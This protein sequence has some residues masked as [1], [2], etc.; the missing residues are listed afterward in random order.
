MEGT[1]PIT[2][3]AIKAAAQRFW[4]QISA[5]QGQE[6]PRFSTGWL[7]G[8]KRRHNIKQYKQHG[9]AGDVDLKVAAI[10]MV[11]I[12]AITD[13]YSLHDIFNMDE[14]G[15][16]WKTALDKTLAHQQLPG[17]KKVKAR[18]TAALCYNASGL[19][20]LPVWLIGTARQSRAF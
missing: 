2:G 20:Q 19:E 4:L 5:Y 17:N 6:I 14:T 18:I 16:Y 12:K 15:L 1:V 13:K 3:D 11:S 9:E 10:A 8:F 7:D